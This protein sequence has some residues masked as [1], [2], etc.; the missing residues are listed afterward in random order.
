MS[1]PQHQPRKEVI[2]ELGL[3]PFCHERIIEELGVNKFKH[4][5]SYCEFWVLLTDNSRMKVGCCLD[6]RGQL[7]DEMVNELMVVHRRFWQAG[8]EEA[9]KKKIEEINQVLQQQ[10]TYYGELDFLRFGLKESDLE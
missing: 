3:C 10:L 1:T 8:I 2:I 7:D 6:C 9:T 4:L 5:P